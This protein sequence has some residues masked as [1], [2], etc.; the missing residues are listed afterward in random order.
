M[1][2]VFRSNRNKTVTVNVEVFSSVRK[3]NFNFLVAV[4]NGNIGDN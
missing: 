2:W 4:V 1:N 3:I